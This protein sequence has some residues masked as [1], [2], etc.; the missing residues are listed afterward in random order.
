MFVASYRPVATAA[1]VRRDGSGRPGLDGG[2]RPRAAGKSV[3]SLCKTHAVTREQATGAPPASAGR[4]SSAAS[5]VDNLA[6]LVRIQAAAHPDHTALIEGVDAARTCS[7]AELDELVE[8][9]AAG[10]AALG[11]LAGHRVCLCLD[12]GIDF[13]VAYLGALRAG[14]VAVP[15][16]PRAATGEL[17]RQLV[18]SNSRIVVADSV[19]VDTVRAAV[20]GVREAINDMGGSVAAPTNVVAGVPS[21]AG[22][23]S[24]EELLNPGRTPVV[25]PHDRERLAVLLY[26]S[27]TSGAPQGAMLTHRALLANLDQVAAIQPP[28][29]RRD[30]IVLGL[31][32]LFHVYGLNCV[33][34]QVLNQG[35]T[36]V[37]ID[38]FDPVATLAAVRTLGLTNL[39]ITPPVVSAWLT[40]PDLAEQLAGVRLIISGA[41]PLDQEQIAEFEAASGIRVHQGY[42]L[43][44]AAPVVTSTLTSPGLHPRAGSVGAPLPGVELQVRDRT[45]APTVDGDLGQVWVRG[46][47]VFSGYWPNGTDGPDDSGWYATGDIGLLGGRG[48]LVLVDRLGDLVIVS[49]F[50]VYPAEVE[51]VIRAVPGVVDV[52]VIGVQNELT[53]EAVLAYVVPAVGVEESTL[54][55]GIR[56]R[57]EA[58]LARFKWPRRVSLVDD[59]PRSANGKVAK[60]RLRA[61]AS[62]AALGL[63]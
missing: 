39:P 37:L 51:D 17:V 16:N 44:E 29:M 8:R 54:L 49:G 18:D 2:K 15:A 34:G 35:A 43:T 30:D 9:C 41:A 32:P 11:L 45:G 4:P 26:T 60:G 33:L 10:L 22:E 19:T 1:S 46:D 12:T 42:G 7:W 6:D 5:T 58:R 56:E 57:C 14:L 23:T 24:F 61:A 21:L 40:Q 53:G 47:N 27:G 28:V 20:A 52:A 3:R 38:H 13:V 50:N 63:T 25:T 59:L 36:L 31:L 62:G 48:E 55:E